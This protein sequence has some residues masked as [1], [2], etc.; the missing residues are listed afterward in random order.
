MSEQPTI[1]YIGGYGRSGSTLLERILGT[2]PGFVSVGE[3]RFVWDRSFG[4]NQLCGCGRP[5]Y[6][7]DFWNAVGDEAF[8]GLQKIDPY[9]A[10]ELRRLV[11]RFR[12]IP[13]YA[14]GGANCLHPRKLA[15]PLSEYEA[16]L[17]KLYRAIQSVS[18]ADVIVDSSKYPPYAFLLNALPFADL[19]VI[20]LVRDSRAVAY[21]WS[22]HRVRPEIIGRS[23]LMPRYGP[24]KA[25]YGWSLRNQSLNLLSRAS[26]A[27][28]RLRYEDLVYAPADHVQKTLRDLDLG[29]AVELPAADGRRVSLSVDHTVSGNP[30]RFRQ[31]D[32]E[33]RPDEEWRTMMRRT[34]RV[35]V[36]ALTSPLLLQYGYLGSSLRNEVGARQ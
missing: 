2:I 3:L 34:D 25:S 7:C 19:R 6:S 5:F 30:M 24:A 14:L 8:G 28:K 29:K 22:R 4:E 9:R 16:L 15:G 27:F 17:N 10:Y 35:V 20:Q 33:L 18:G 13:L 11:E 21:S 31:G 12:Y 32:I 23:T 36:T 1:L 26:A